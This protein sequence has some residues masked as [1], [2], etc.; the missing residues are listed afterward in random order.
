M[1]ASGQGYW[2]S[3]WQRNCRY[4]PVT[5][6]QWNC[7][8]VGSPSRRDVPGSPI[9]ACRSIRCPRRH[10]SFDMDGNAS[11]ND[12]EDRPIG[13][14]SGAL[15]TMKITN[16]H[17]VSQG[18]V[19]FVGPETLAQRATWCERQ[20]FDILRSNRASTY[21]YRYST[22]STKSLLSLAITPT[23]PLCSAGGEQSAPIGPT[24]AHSDP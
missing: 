22:T 2:L 12:P 19:E 24:E 4:R 20:G 16:F 10:P 17:G 21:G 3:H 14:R 11:A 18:G 8:S 23:S 13:G 6:D 9:S 7:L 1:P 5:R 15:T